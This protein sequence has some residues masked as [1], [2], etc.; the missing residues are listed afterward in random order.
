MMGAGTGEDGMITITDMDTIERSNLSRQFLFRPPDIDKPKSEAA[1]RAMLEMNPDVKM[2]CFTDP[3]GTTTEHIFT[4]EL[5]DSQTVLINALDNEE[6]RNYVDTKAVWHN[7][8]L[9]ESATTGVQASCKAII[10]Q[11]TESIRDHKIMNDDN[12][13]PMCTLKGA[14]YEATH[15]I[16]WAIHDETDGSLNKLF[17]LLPSGLKQYLEDQDKYLNSM[18]LEMATEYKGYKE[19][20]D[21]ITHALKLGDVDSSFASCV[22]WARHTFDKL[23]Y[24]EPAAKLDLF[25]ADYII[26]TDGQPFYNGKV[27]TPQPQHFDPTNE[28]HV[29]F[30]YSAANLR[31]TTLGVPV[32]R[33]VNES[34]LSEILAL[35][36][37]VAELPFVPG[38]GDKEVDETQE[39][40]EVMGETVSKQD[41]EALIAT[42]RVHDPHHRLQACHV[43]PQKFEK[44]DDSN[45][46]IDYCT[47]TANM[48][49]MTFSIESS[50]RFDVKH[51]AGKIIPAIQTTTAMVVGYV[52]VEL[53][54]IIQGRRAAS[55][56]FEGVKAC[57]Q[58]QGGTL[59]EMPPTKKMEKNNEDYIEMKKMADQMDEVVLIL[60]QK[61]TNHTMVKIEDPTMTLEAI[62]E[63][64]KKQLDP[65]GKYE[66]T[67]NAIIGE[68]GT[69][70]YGSSSKFASAK[71]MT[72]ANVMLEFDTSG[73]KGSSV[74]QLPEWVNPTIEIEDDDTCSDVFHAP[75][76]IKVR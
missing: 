54:Q 74:E 16:E 28:W 63:E 70:M 72:F 69:Q 22:E 30:V 19:K 65:E 44:D 68:S 2:T 51:I 20:L 15:C 50:E 12:A 55:D 39:A 46:H 3:V 4:P 62:F 64:I 48:R 73:W 31:A 66:L 14:P 75:I 52:M 29:W 25:P 5:W 8:P 67:F 49:A 38:G 7:V 35:A 53:Y 40:D 37:E 41:L 10:P 61:A 47:A 13:I 71:E 17:K 60:P 36:N 56:F 11:K 23:F 45:F 6:A 43:M 59:F 21:F 9:L 34:S 27:R 42:L 26:K 58:P 18:D 76:Y 57:T 24:H 32:R 1:Q 33:I